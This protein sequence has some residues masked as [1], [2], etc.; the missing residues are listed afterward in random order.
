MKEAILV[1]F[2]QFLII[3]KR[4]NDDVKNQTILYKTYLEAETAN[5]KS[6]KV[7]LASIIFPSTNDFLPN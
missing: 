5:I 1:F 6:Q 2:E 7:P 4:C 3:L